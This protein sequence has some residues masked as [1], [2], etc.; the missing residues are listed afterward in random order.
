MATPVE[1]EVASRRTGCRARGKCHNS[2]ARIDRRGCE[3]MG[4][5]RTI[6]SRVRIE[7]Y[8]S[9]DSLFPSRPCFH[10]LKT[11][12]P[13]NM[14]NA[15]AEVARSRDGIDQTINEQTIARTA[16]TNI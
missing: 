11:E 10:R 7:T 5:R 2:A 13:I 6:P 1:G 14:G 16:K 8:S 15:A 12:H 3:G 4:R 9:A